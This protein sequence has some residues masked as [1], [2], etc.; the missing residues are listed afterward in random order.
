MQ[1]EIGKQIAM[2][3]KR[4]NMTQAELAEK[5]SLSYQAI[6][7]WEHSYT[8][9]DITLLPEIA[10]IF[11]VSIDELFNNN[12]KETTKDTIILPGEVKDDTL[13][14]VVAKGNQV[15]KR[16]ELQEI[17]SNHRSTTK[18]LDHNGFTVATTVYD[19]FSVELTGEPLNI[20]CALSLKC[21]D[22]KGNVKSGTSIQCE[23]VEGSVQSGSSIKCN[24]IGGDVQSSGSINCGNISGNVKC[25][26]S[27]NSQKISGSVICNGSVKIYG[28]D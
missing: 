26:G 4:N 23:N 27:I 6:S 5:L 8:Y 15:V 10:K 9:P 17:L 7:Q 1:M 3:R 19:S 16:N 25:F 20:E 11:N 12:P 14:I 24:N 22:V 21:K 28:K 2:L 18:Y 13:Y